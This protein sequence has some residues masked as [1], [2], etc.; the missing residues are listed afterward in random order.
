MAERG[1]A[2]AVGPDGGAPA[3]RRVFDPAL[4]Q[5]PQGFRV[6][7][8]QLDGARRAAFL[9]ARQRVLQA[10]LVAIATGPDRSRLVL[11]GSAAM[12]FHVGERARPPKDLDFIVDGET[13]SI[14]DP[15]SLA[16]FD[17]LEALVCGLRVEGVEFAAERAARSGIWTYERAPGCRLVVPW[18]MDGGAWDV[19][20]LDLVFGEALRRPVETLPSGLR[21]A[22]AEL[23]L[24]WKILW[25]ASDMYPQ[26]KDLYDAAVL[27]A[28]T[29]IDR[30]LLAQTFA[31][32]DERAPANG[33]IEVDMHLEW[34]GFDDALLP[35]GADRKTAARAWWQAVNRALA[36]AWDG[37]GD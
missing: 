32:A 21:I 25:L 9:E 30:S 37:P 10:A 15:R 8:P 22:P 36:A 35:D 24:A 1:T 7:D 6:D 29:S 2:D 5:Y 19:L 23:A 31:D 3:G 12:P 14:D 26:A 34:A 18:I 11:R 16:L 4:K 27:A 17:R 33:R 28:A 13:G 20:Q